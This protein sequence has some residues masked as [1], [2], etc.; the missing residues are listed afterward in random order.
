MMRKYRIAV[1]GAGKVGSALAIA[2]QNA[3][4]LVMGVASRTQ[5]AAETLAARVGAAKA[6]IKIKQAVRQAEVILI[7]TP[8]RQIAVVVE[9]L[10]KEDAIRSGQFVFHACGSQSAE[11]LAAVRD[12]G[13]IIGSMH[14]LQA[15]STI[16]GAVQSI[17]G[18]YFAIDGDAAA[19]AAAKQMIVDIGGQSFVI[20]SAQRALYHAAA[21]MASNYTVAVIHSAVQMFKALGITETEAIAALSPIM[22]GTFANIVRAGTV[23]ALTGPIVRGDVGTIE[24]HLAQIAELSPKESTIYAQL[25]IYTEKIA[26]ERKI[27]TEEEGRKLYTIFRGFI[28]NCG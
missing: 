12:A 16:E 10:L 19:I 17:P 28:H 6:G 18:T 3:G 20:P 25:G 7:T 27:Y 15:F 22:R 4:H 23:N 2:L 9:A 24:K 11:T 13:A 8:D 5:S 26:E 1:I 21:C 14:P